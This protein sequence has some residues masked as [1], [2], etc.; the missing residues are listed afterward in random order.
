MANSDFRKC[1][2]VLRMVIA[3]DTPARQ[4]LEVWLQRA[5]E[6]GKLVYGL[7]ISQAALITCLVSDHVHQH[8]HF[9][10][11]DQGG[12]ALAASQL[13][14]QR[15]SLSRGQVRTGATDTD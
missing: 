11:G 15:A 7:Q 1:D 6:E 3:V 14:Q 2:E 10:D 4:K 5:F 8:V 13:K 9:L 12:Y